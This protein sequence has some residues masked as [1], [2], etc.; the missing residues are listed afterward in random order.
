MQTKHWAAQV[1]LHIHIRIH[2]HVHMHMHIHIHMATPNEDEMLAC[3]L[4]DMAA[5]MQIL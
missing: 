4:L 3:C 5:C 2:I 1:C